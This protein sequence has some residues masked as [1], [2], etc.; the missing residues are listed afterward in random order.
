[1]IGAPIGVKKGDAGSR[2]RAQLGEARGPAQSREHKRSN[3]RLAF[4]GGACDQ[5]KDPSVCA[6]GYGRSADI[7][8]R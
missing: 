6:S 2:K 5:K 1:M 3:A 8:H 4:C 7:A